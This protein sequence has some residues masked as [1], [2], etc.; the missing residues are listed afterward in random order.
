MRASEERCWTQPT[1][2]A[3]APVGWNLRRFDPFGPREGFDWPDRLPQPE[4]GPLFRDLGP[5]VS[6]FDEISKALT[7]PSDGDSCQDGCAA[8]LTLV[9]ALTLRP[10]R[11]FN[12]PSPSVASAPAPDPPRPA[13]PASLGPSP[14]SASASASLSA[15]RS[16]WPPIR[17]FLS[18]IFSFLA[19]LFP[20]P[21]AV[22]ST[23]MVR[24]F[25]LE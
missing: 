22:N 6:V 14:P 5:A 15:L 21:P 17:S 10:P 13:L 25:R 9:L 2:S 18:R 4:G 3:L 7:S 16:L 1:T 24:P 20:P 8:I 23:L 12:A 19:P 11:V